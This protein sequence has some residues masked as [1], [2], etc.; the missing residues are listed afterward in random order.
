[1]YYAIHVEIFLNVTKKFMNILYREN[2][3]TKKINK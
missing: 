1:M 3:L 2:A